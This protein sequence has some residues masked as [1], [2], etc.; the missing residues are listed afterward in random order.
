MTF[1][2][3]FLPC[4]LVFWACHAFKLSRRLFPT[5]CLAPVGSMW[6]CCVLFG[7]GPKPRQARDGHSWR[8]VIHCEW[9][10]LFSFCQRAPRLSSPSLLGGVWKSGVRLSGLIADPRARLAV[11][12]GVPVDA[13][14]APALARFTVLLGPLPR[15]GGGWLTRRGACPSRV[16][17]AR[18]LLLRASLVLLERSGL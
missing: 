8:M 17:C 13:S 10:P 16:V 3:R 5:S 4:S 18:A 11:V 15:A 1:S 7:P 9:R 6:C 14:G 12:R 2:R